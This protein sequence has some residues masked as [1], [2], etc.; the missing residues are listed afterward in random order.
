L[1]VGDPLDYPLAWIAMKHALMSARWIRRCCLLVATLPGNLAAAGPENYLFVGSD[2]LESLAAL[3]QRTDIGGVQ[4]VYSWKS[5][6]PAE[7]QYDFSRIEKDLRYLDT[8]NR[9]LFIQLQDRFFEIEHK[10]VP[11]YLLTE[12]IYGGGLV[13]QVDNP[14]ENQPKGHGWATQQ[15]NP[16]VRERFQRLLSALAQ[17]FD[18]RV[19]GINLPETAIDI[20]VKNDKT[21]FTC[22]KYFAAEMEN[23]AF[24]RRAFQKSHVVQYVNF[25]P[26]EWDNDRKFMSRTFAFAHAN[27]VGLGGPDIV[28][29][30]KAQMKNAYPFFNRYK[31]RLSLVAMAVQEPTLTYTN[32]ET[33]KRF[34]REEF[35]AFAEDYLGVDIIFWSTRSPWLKIT[36]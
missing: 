22:E 11:Q 1:A 28:P 23:L 13:P 5:L 18:G 15:W 10:N 29:Y 32:P 27:K 34:R 6:E 25:W 4:I 35:V 3:I 17:R 12:P 20:D 21:G 26:C 33:K 36:R 8:M 30:R 24:A 2:E 19:F 31:D 7:D 9:K 16:A 14:G